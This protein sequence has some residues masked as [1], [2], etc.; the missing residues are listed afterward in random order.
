ML[1]AYNGPWLDCPSGQGSKANIKINSKIS[2][3]AQNEASAKIIPVSCLMS[4]VN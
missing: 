3:G 1:W 4:G 2:Y